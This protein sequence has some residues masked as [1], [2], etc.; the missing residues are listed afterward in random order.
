MA[1]TCAIRVAIDAIPACAS[2]IPT[3]LTVK[4]DKNIGAFGAPKYPAADE[5]QQTVFGQALK[6]HLADTL[7]K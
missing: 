5:K 2:I 6:D 4:T 7:N 1:I 3:F